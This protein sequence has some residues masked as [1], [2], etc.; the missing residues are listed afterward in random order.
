VAAARTVAAAER[1]RRSGDAGQV[2]TAVMLVVTAGLV[3][4]TTLGVL[5][6]GAAVDER[7]QAQTAADAAA[8]GGATDIRDGL[9]ETLTG[10]RSPE[11][12]VD[13]FTCGSGR[14]GALD[15]AARNG[16]EVTSYCY[17]PLTDRAEVSVENRASGDP[18]TGVAVASAVAS[19][20]LAP[21]ECTFEPDPS[22]SP[23][24]DGPDDPEGPDEPD[25]AGVVT[26]TCG[27]LVVEFES[28]GGELRL[29]TPP[30]EL[31]RQAEDAFEPRLVE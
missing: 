12:F 9:V 14:D 30:D 17:D 15:L 3:A 10:L 26:L 18:A 29:R 31:A 6:L 5:R 23:S 21:A 7:G 22:A 4:V 27:D 24:P 20:G 19:V 25:G 11:G 1:R 2:A 28:D 13:L 8:L 16:A